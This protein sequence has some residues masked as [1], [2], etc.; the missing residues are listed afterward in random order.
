MKAAVI[1]RALNN[2]FWNSLTLTGDVYKRQ[3]AYYCELAAYQRVSFDFNY[4]SI[5]A[6]CLR[7]RDIP[8]E[9]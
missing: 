4:T 1:I 9:V 2:T 5:Q 6:V 3:G 8:A 7:R